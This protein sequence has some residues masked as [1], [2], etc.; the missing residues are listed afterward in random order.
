M[1]QENFPKYDI[2]GFK[3][4]TGVVAR[5]HFDFLKSLKNKPELIYNILSITT[6]EDSVS[7]WKNNIISTI[8]LI[9]PYTFKEISSLNLVGIYCLCLAQSHLKNKIEII[10]KNVIKTGLFGTLGNK[11]YLTLN[12][13]FPDS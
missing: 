7:D 6:N 3:S 9:Y 11:G 1:E 2:L 5:P 8:N 12:L 4:S 10:D 13:N